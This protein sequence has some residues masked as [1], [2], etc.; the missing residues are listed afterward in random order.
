[1][2]SRQP[3][4]W[5]GDLV[6]LIKGLQTEEAKQAFIISSTGNWPLGIQTTNLDSNSAATNETGR[7]LIA[8]RLEQKEKDKTEKNFSKNMSSMMENV[9][10]ALAKLVQNDAATGNSTIHE[11]FVSFKQTVNARIWKVL[12]RM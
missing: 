2:H 10:N 8:C 11:D 12:K 4:V 3:K 9:G 5:Y 7:K 1:V 6:V